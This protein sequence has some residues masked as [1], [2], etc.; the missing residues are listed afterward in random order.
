VRVT[1]KRASVEVVVE[2]NDTMRPG[3][4]SLPNGLGLSYPDDRGRPIVHGVAINELT[5][6]DDRDWLAGTPHHKHVRAR[7]EALVP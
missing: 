7:V 2:V 5:S 6:T 3:H 1:T 4:V